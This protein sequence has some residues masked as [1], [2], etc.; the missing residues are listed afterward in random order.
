M[1]RFRLINEAFLLNVHMSENDFILGKMD[2]FNEG[3]TEA[4]FLKARVRC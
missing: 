3:V 4:D 2:V 1:F